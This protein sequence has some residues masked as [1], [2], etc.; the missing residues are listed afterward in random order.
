MPGNAIQDPGPFV[1]MGHLGRVCR[2]GL[3]TRGNTSLEPSDVLEAFRR[4]VRYFNWCGHSDGLSAA[5]R[6]FV[7]TS[8]GRRS[9]PCSSTP[10]MR[11]GL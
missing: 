3:S 10:G 11:K 1:Q 5:V 4:G 6:G 2:L 8:V 7:P 9:S